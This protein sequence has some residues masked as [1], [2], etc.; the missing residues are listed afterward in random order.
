MQSWNP[1]ELLAIG[2]LAYNAGGSTL[3]D[4]SIGQYYNNF[5][6][7]YPSPNYLAGDYLSIG[8]KTVEDGKKAG[9]TMST[10]IPLAFRIHLMVALGEVMIAE[11]TFGGF[12]ES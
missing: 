12:G 5:I 6:Y 3:Q 8:K 7:P 11:I 1:S 9:L 4:I 2:D 10:T